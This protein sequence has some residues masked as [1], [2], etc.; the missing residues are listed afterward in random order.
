MRSSSELNTRQQKELAR[1]KYG[2][3]RLDKWI[4][5]RWKTY[6]HIPYKQLIE[7]C[8]KYNL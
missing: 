8:K 4:K 3:R 2:E 6:G 1:K 7:Q 5:W